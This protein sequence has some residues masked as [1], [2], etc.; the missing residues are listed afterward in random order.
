M[1]RLSPVVLALI[2]GA[3]AARADELSATR[4]MPLVELTHSVDIRIENGV[5][6]YTVRR[7]F[8]NSGDTADQV[9][10][11]LGLPYGAAA[12]G[13]RIKARD[14][15]Y[16]GE[17][18]ERE[19]AAKLYEEMT[20]LGQYAPK[21]PALLAWMWADTLSLQMFPVMPRSVSTV[22]YTLTAPTRYA[23]GRYF[24][25]YPRVAEGATKLAT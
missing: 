2:A 15:W 6:T 10:L 16:A 1:T 9:E 12:T 24:V 5:A 22:E 11:V 13:L 20:G 17:L 4:S 19:Q 25:S 21:D 8:Q 23:G 3:S 18:M 7:T 14:R